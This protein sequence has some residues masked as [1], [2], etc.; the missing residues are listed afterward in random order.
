MSRLVPV[1][2]PGVASFTTPDE[3]PLATPRGIALGLKLASA[4]WLAVAAGVLAWWLP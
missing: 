1:K 3:N 2:K 4:F